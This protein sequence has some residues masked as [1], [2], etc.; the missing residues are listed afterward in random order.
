MDKYGRGDQGIS[1]RQRQRDTHTE[2][3]TSTTIVKVHKKE[4]DRKQVNVRNY[5][6][7]VVN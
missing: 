6:M 1:K 2:K 4:Y 5:K 3:Q 7:I